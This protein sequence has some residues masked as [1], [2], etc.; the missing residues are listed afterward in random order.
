MKELNMFNFTY[1]TAKVTNFNIFSNYF[2]ITI[3]IIGILLNLA[4]FLILKSSDLIRYNSS[5][6]ILSVY[7][8]VIFK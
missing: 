4:T 1:I 5:I 6:R 2:I 7:L 8:M 3:I